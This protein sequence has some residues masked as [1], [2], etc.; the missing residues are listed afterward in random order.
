MDKRILELFRYE[1]GKLF[2]A[3]RSGCRSV[4]GGEAGCIA[5]IGRRYVQAFG[6]KYLVHRIIW[7][8]HNGGN[9]PEFLDHKDGNPLNN[10]ISNLRPATKSTNAMNRKVRV[11]NEC[12]VTGVYR[13]GKRFIA[14]IYHNGIMNYLGIF[15]DLI[16][17]KTAYETEA[18]KTF[19]EYAKCL[20]A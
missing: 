1:D 15:K 17:A 8:L 13:H 5:T 18:K 7:A 11:D 14:H 3:K 12:G 4:V 19:K 9:C 10:L 20:S 16:S 2:W 6:K